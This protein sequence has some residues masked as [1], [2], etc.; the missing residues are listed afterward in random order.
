MFGWRMEEAAKLE[1][2]ITVN[3]VLTTSDRKPYAVANYDRLGQPK[4]AAQ[5]RQITGK[6]SRPVVLMRYI[7]T[8]M[9]VKIN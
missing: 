1:F 4:F 7:A 6:N 8:A 2:T 3:R 9:S 5:P